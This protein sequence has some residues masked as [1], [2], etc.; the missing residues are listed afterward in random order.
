M[1]LWRQRRIRHEKFFDSACL[2]HQSSFVVMAVSNRLTLER[3]SH[4]S[5]HIPCDLRQ[6]SGG[7]DLGEKSCTNGSSRSSCNQDTL[8]AIACRSFMV[9]GL[10]TGECECTVSGFQTFGDV[11]R[12]L[13]GNH[14]R[15]HRW[16][17][18]WVA[19]VVQL[20]KACKVCL[21]WA[22]T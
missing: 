3:K 14:R 18:G 8:A 20:E 9:V 16:V 10:Q 1:P 4:R 11:G 6:Q 19:T 21:G 7:N 15:D 5:G 17:G 22:A 13:A 2:F 12:T